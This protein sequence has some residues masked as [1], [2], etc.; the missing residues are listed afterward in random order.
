MRFYPIDHTNSPNPSAGCSN[1]AVGATAVRTG[2]LR[3]PS[4]IRQPDLLSESPFLHVSVFLSQ[5]KIESAAPQNM[6]SF[7]EYLPG[8]LIGMGRTD[9]PTVLL[10]A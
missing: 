9:E 2:A 4:F 1:G 5:D 6:L 7:A 8:V 10:L 3:L